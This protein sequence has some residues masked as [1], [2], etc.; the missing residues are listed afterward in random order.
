MARTLRE[1]GRPR[2]DWDRD[3]ALVKDWVA[4][5]RARRWSEDSVNAQ[6]CVLRRFHDFCR[7]RHGKD[8]YRSDQGR[9]EVTWEDA[10]AFLEDVN[11]STTRKL[12]AKKNVYFTILSFYRFR[13]EEHLD[14]DVKKRDW[15]N[16]QDLPAPKTTDEPESGW[17]PF[18]LELV[19]PIL[20]A[21][22]SYETVDHG[23][24]ANEDG[25]LVALLLYTAGRAQFFG[26][27]ANQADLQRCSIRTRIKGDYYEEIPLHDELVRILRTLLERNTGRRMLFAFARYAYD[28]R[29]AWPGEGTC[30]YEGCAVREGLWSYYGV[31]KDE[32]YCTPHLRRT[33]GIAR[34]TNRSFVKWAMGRV[35]AAL[36]ERVPDALEEVWD[37]GTQ[38][39]VR[40][41]VHV[42]AHRFRETVVTHGLALGFTPEQVTQLTK[43]KSDA[44]KK[45]NK[46]S[47]AQMRETVG[48]V[49]LAKASEAAGRGEAPIRVKSE[50][51]QVLVV[52]RD[53]LRQE[54]EERRRMA[55][56]NRQLRGQV[57]E[58]LQQIRTGVV[59]PDV[60]D[61]V[62]T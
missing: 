16:V 17:K 6:R 36:H 2:A 11:A 39:F 30:A 10:R 21:S 12:R 55:D 7:R 43:H 5:A 34:N 59:R 8:Y 28:D 29:I 20:Q 26:L 60:Q 4:W 40:R 54:R 35:E 27:R 46:P 47:I 31:E 61:Q 48:R 1:N 41:P 9:D 32:P 19:Y 18:A 14:D 42:H 33:I 37:A 22:R 51:E 15:D 24:R 38:A 13:R 25:E 49:D 58:L 56:E 50:L 45:Y 23:G 57:T 52:V 3:P 53:E 44:W 62:T